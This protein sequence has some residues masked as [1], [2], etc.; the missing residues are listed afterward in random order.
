[1]VNWD[2]PATV[3]ISTVT[4]YTVTFKEIDAEFSVATGCDSIDGVTTTCTVALAT[5]QGTPFSLVLGSSVL[6]KVTA[7]NAVGTS[8]ASSANGE[9]A[10]V[11]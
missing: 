7:T 11:I 10:A 6:V 5:L 1:M 9:G 2:A 8:D 3:G 4:S